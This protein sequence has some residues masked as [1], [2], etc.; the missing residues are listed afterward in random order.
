MRLT[1]KQREDVVRDEIELYLSSY[2]VLHGGQYAMTTEERTAA[3]QEGISAYF[4]EHPEEWV[5]LEGWI[6]D[7]SVE[8]ETLLVPELVVSI[9]SYLQ[10][11]MGYEWL[12]S[13]RNFAYE[14][15][16]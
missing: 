7:S 11:D 3:F 14:Y 2:K 9:H 13:E 12:T 8:L 1:R 16:F 15:S 5:P 4:Q 6:E 10:D